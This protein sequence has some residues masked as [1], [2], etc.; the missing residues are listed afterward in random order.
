MQHRSE[1]SEHNTA[2]ERFHAGADASRSA[3]EHLHAEAHDLLQ[4]Q[5]RE[6][7]NQRS[8]GSQ[9]ELTGKGFPELSVGD[10]SNESHG[11][12]G[13][14]GRQTVKGQHDHDGK[15]GQQ[16]AGGHHVHD[17]HPGQH[18]AEGHHSHHRHSDH[19][20]AEEHR[21]QHFRHNVVHDQ[22]KSE[23]GKPDDTNAKNTNGGGDSVLGERY[24]KQVVPEQMQDKL[25]AQALKL[26]G[27]QVTDSEIKYARAVVNQESSFNAGDTNHWDSNARAGHPSK[28]WAQVIDSTFRQFHVPGHGDIWNP[29]DNLAAGIRYADSRYGNR[30]ADHN[31]L[32]WVALHRSRHHLGY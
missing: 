21:G 15:P 8:A 29:V 20:G 2:S 18:G 11:Y 1:N 12:H 6:R 23:Q 27:H 4:A 14:P 30:D 19:Q 26:A 17:G 13:H 22:V 16:G 10:T 32:R 3:G 9:S 28:G 24:R 5:S 31:G 25:I 7:Q